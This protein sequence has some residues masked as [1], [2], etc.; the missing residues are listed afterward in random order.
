VRFGRLGKEYRRIAFDRG[1]L[2]RDPT[3]EWVTPGHPLFEA[4]RESTWRRVAEDLRRGAVFHDLYRD[5]P[6]RLDVFAASVR[7]GTGQTLHRRLFVVE[8]KEEALWLRQPTVFLD[9]V[10]APGAAV[11]GV[12][13]PDR[14]E[15]E[16]F[17]L[18]EALEAFEEEVRAARAREVETIANHVELAL[19][20][21]IDRQQRKVNE[22]FLRQQEGEDVALA[23]QEAERRLDELNRRLERRR[24]EL[25]RQ[26]R[27]TLADVAHLGS[28][29]VLP[30]PERPALAEEGVGADPE[31][32]R[33]A[34]EMAIRYELEAGREPKSVEAEN[35]GFDLLSRDPATGAIRFI[36]VKGR[37]GTDPVAL[38]AN[39]YRTAE[40][41]GAD[42]WLYAVFDCRG[43]P[44]LVPV[45]DP[46]RLGWEPR[47]R[48]E[49]YV[50]RPEAIQTAAEEG[51]P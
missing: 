45:R 16:R 31:V 27:F 29:W 10:P 44:R 40:R 7:D 41:L 36:E 11:P 19:D 48:V 15:T 2:E 20:T 35:R 8:A 3:L 37:A 6:A 33:V 25:D 42:Y 32:E 21:L 47:V 46:A 14:E 4:V 13:V 1:E 28:A 38:T 51:D 12:P 43:V 34:V 9:I 39:E 23:L 49:H 22:L 18:E 30:H 5:H 24:A 50:L 26:R 17:L